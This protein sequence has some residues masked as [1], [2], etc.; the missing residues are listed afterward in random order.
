MDISELMTQYSEKHQVDKSISSLD[1][2][3]RQANEVL[4]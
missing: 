4:V 2:E 1:A 3:Y